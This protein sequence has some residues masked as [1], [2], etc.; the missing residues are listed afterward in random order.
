MTT[1]ATRYRQPPEG[2][3]TARLRA[4]ISHWIHGQQQGLR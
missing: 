2:L 3:I 4:W 1:T